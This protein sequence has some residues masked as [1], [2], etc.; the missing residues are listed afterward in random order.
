[1]ETRGTTCGCCLFTRRAGRACGLHGTF[2][3]ILNQ[4]FN[5]IHM[6]PSARGTVSAFSNA[7]LVVYKKLVE[8]RNGMAHFV[9]KQ[10]GRPLNAIPNA[11]DMSRDVDERACCVLV[12]QCCCFTC[13]P[14]CGYLISEGLKMCLECVSDR[15][16]RRADNQRQFLNDSDFGPLG[17]GPDVDNYVPSENFKGTQAMAEIT[18]TGPMAQI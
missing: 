1:M 13:V 6:R 2:G 8:R 5:V 9:L 16:N 10:C 14:T 4:C 3:V 7:R 11:L 17:N 18:P 12:Q 15:R